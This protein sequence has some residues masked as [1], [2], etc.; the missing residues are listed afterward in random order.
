MGKIEKLGYLVGNLAEFGKE[1]TIYAA[2]PWTEYSD[3]V[4]AK[5]PVGGG[6]PSDI[7]EAGLKYFLEVS[8]AREFMEDWFASLDKKP[9]SSISC[10]RLIEYAINDA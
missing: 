3:A 5:E 10:Q 7:K 9:E 4:V 1:D 2:E 8:I 6:V